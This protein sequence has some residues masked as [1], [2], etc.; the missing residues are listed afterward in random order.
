MTVSPGVQGM[1]FAPSSDR[2][3]LPSGELVFDVT[4]P[5]SNLITGAKPFL[6]FRYLRNGSGGLRAQ[7]GG[8][9]LIGFHEPVDGVTTPRF[10]LSR[11][12]DTNHTLA[13]I[14]SA[15]LA[16]PIDS[17]PKDYMGNVWRRDVPR[18]S[19]SLYSDRSI[20]R[21]FGLLARSGSGGGVTFLPHAD[22][23]PNQTYRVWSDY[24]TIE[25]HVCWF[26]VE[27]TKGRIE[28]DKLC[29]KIDVIE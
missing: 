9:F 22:G 19:L 18:T 7:H 1:R 17:P 13:A 27:Q 11:Y 6:E 21:V 23:S 15:G 25:D 28:A 5:G 29:G 10:W 16:P 12:V 8:H 26:L 24:R 14:T 20:D 2:N 4:R 3:L